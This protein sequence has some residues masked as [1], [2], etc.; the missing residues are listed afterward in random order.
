MFDVLDAALRSNKKLAQSR[1]ALDQWMLAQILVIERQKIE[2]ERQGS[3]VIASVMEQVELRNALAVETDNFG[4][5]D[6]MTFDPCRFLDNAG[7]SVSTSRRRSS[8]RGVP[9][10]PGRAPVNGSR[11]ASIR[12]PSQDRSGAGRQLWDGRA[13]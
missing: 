10:H 2:S 11:H 3:A 5:D 13:E 9:G 12:E 7:D 1:L 4:V 6:R 8:C